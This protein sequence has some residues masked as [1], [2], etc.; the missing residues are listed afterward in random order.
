MVLTQFS[1]VCVSSFNKI[2]CWG[3]TVFGASGTAVK[4]P[5][6]CWRCS[7]GG[8]EITTPSVPLNHV[9]RLNPAM[10]TRWPM[11]NLAHNALPISCFVWVY[12]KTSP[13]H[14][15]VRRKRLGA[16]F[17]GIAGTM[18]MNVLFTRGRKP[19]GAMN[20]LNR[21]K[22]SSEKKDRNSR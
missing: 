8:T 4:T 22:T 5:M 21:P 12:D 14:D 19:R 1:F 11:R 16:S 17:N 7:R 18:S 20:P 2:K 10:R 6:R 9:P 15:A 13:G 3:A